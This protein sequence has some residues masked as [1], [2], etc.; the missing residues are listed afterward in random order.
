MIKIVS[1]V[2]AAVAVLSACATAPPSAVAPLAIVNS[3]VSFDGDIA[4]KPTDLVFVLVPDANPRTPGVMLGA[5][6]SLRLALPREFQRNA[7]VPLSPDNDTNA[8][9]T[10]GWPQGSVRQAQQYRIGLDDRAHALTFTALQEIAANGANAPGIKAIHVRGRTFINPG[11]GS[12][13]VTLTRMDAQ[14]RQLASWQGEVKVLATSTG[15]RLAPT[16]FHL[17]PGSLGDFQSVPIGQQAPRL[18]GLLLWGA[19]G[20]P[21]NG[22]G[23]TPRDLTRF[24]RY[25]G[26]LLVRDSN[27][28]GS[29]DPAIDTVVGGIIGA[30]PQGA[31]GQ[32]AASPIGADGKPVLSGQALRNDA[33]PNG[34]KP[35]PGLLPI[36]F[37]SGNLPGLY[38]PVVELTGGNSYR[39][40]IEATKP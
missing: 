24:P 20:A 19:D 14:G 26:G 36:L 9:L 1:L 13:P 8:V 3:P 21:L 34:G 33:F 2:T 30:A 31:T 4:G 38:Q 39:F 7:Q 32:L 27:A 28:D 25:T 6:E 23:V 15:P 5:G 18:L 37:R 10:K 22:V 40:T 11:A 12:Y 29:L 35:N 16:N 17:A